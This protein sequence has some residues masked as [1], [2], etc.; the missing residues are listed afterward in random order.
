MSEEKSISQVLYKN[1]NL[2]LIDPGWQSFFFQE[3]PQNYFQQL[4]TTLEEE[5]QKGKCYP[6]KTQI[7]RL[8]QEISLEKIKVVIIGQDPYYQPGVADGLAFSTQKLNYTPLTLQNIYRELKND[9]GYS[10][11]ATANLLP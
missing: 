10:I 6:P 4:L 8:F 2:H 7:F 5:Y 9:S 11:P 1:F 3:L